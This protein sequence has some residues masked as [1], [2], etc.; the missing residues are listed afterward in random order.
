MIVISVVII[1]RKSQ[2]TCLHIQF[3]SSR[4]AVRTFVRMNETALKLP[5]ENICENI[6]IISK[7]DPH[8]IT[9]YGLYVILSRKC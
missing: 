6:T 2:N 3:K 5:E 9:R 7:K 4:Q 8:K 1:M